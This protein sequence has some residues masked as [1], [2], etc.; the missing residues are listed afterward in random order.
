MRI[1]AVGTA[2]IGKER[3]AQAGHGT[4]GGGEAISFDSHLLERAYEEVGEWVVVLAIEGEV[5]A[6]FET[7]ACEEDRHVVGRVLAGIAEIATVDNRRLV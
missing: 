6:V 1:E 7:A 3:S 2:L 5:L 4:G